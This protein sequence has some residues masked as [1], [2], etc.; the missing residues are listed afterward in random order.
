MAFNKADDNSE[1]HKINTNQS[2]NNVVPPTDTIDDANKP[3]P[4]SRITGQ[5]ASKDLFIENSED[6]EEM[7]GEKAENQLY[8]Q[9]SGCEV[10][11]DASATTCSDN[12]TPEQIFGVNACYNFRIDISER[13]GG[14]S[15]NVNG[16]AVYVV[17]AIDKGCFGDTIGAITN[18]E[19]TLATNAPTDSPTLP[20]DS[21]STL[22]SEVQSTS[23]APAKKKPNNKMKSKPKKASEVQ[24]A[25]RAPATTKPKKKMKSKP[26][27]AGEL[28]STS[29]APA[30]K[31][32]SRRYQL[33]YKALQMPPQ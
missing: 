9:T 3:S 11:T 13:G 6:F 15:C 2:S 17:E 30:T 8:A 28:P 19:I 23:R 5:A 20:T 29:R 22:P 10:N 12:F 31:K 7:L 32:P 21:P 18:V 33:K 16:A 27:K 4:E 26:K 1:K 25:S 14:G 24:S